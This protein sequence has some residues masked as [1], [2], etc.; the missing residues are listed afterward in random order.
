MSV[1][2]EAAVEPLA[3]GAKARLESGGRRLEVA[4]NRS[5]GAIERG[6]ARVVTDGAV[7]TLTGKPAVGRIEV[8][9]PPETDSRFTFHFPR[10]THGDRPRAA[11]PV[12]RERR[13]FD[14]GVQ[15]LKC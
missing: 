4:V 10:L 1:P 7:F 2:F 6:V 11:P 15:P 9:L 12:K 8:A 3:V 14:G 13:V 5:D